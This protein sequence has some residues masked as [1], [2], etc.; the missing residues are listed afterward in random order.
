M[1][2]WCLQSTYVV[3][4]FLYK[5]QSFD[6]AMF[7]SPPVCRPSWWQAFTPW[8]GWHGCNLSETNKEWQWLHRP[9]AAT[10][11]IQQTAVNTRSST[12]SELLSFAQYCSLLPLVELNRQRK[13]VNSK[14]K[15]ISF[16]IFKSRI[17]IYNG[18]CWSTL[19]NS[20]PC[21]ANI[22]DTMSA[23]DRHGKW[24]KVAGGP[25]STRRENTWLLD[26]MWLQRTLTGHFQE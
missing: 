25:H 12:N 6:T 4:C 26:M 21:F 9:K 23:A 10:E 2:L 14:S 3:W 1:F 20:Q 5:I 13:N 22:T 18:L 15:K 17:H 24:F 16:N 19:K 7:Q 11:C 8:R